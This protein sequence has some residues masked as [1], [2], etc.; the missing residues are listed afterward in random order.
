MTP[1]EIEQA[2]VGSR[3][4]LLSTPADKNAWKVPS[5]LK[6][7]RCGGQS[8][9]PSGSPSGRYVPIGGLKTNN[10]GDEAGLRFPAYGLINLP[11][12]LPA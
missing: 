1:T 2:L 10:M 3:N 12:R 5:R 8:V 11:S 4:T 9:S 6:A 7:M